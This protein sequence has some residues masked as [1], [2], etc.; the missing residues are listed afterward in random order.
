MILLKKIST[1]IP[2]LFTIKTN[3]AKKR[4][5]NETAR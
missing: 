3:K 1:V 4:A 2:F 5:I